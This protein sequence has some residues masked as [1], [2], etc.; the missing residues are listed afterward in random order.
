MDEGRPCMVTTCV[1]NSGSRTAA[2]A[3]PVI[4]FIKSHALISALVSAE[5]ADNVSR[6]QCN[7]LASR[8]NLKSVIN[9]P[10]KRTSQRINGI[11]WLD[12]DAKVY[13]IYG[14]FKVL[15]Y[16]LDLIAGRWENYLCYRL[17]HEYYYL[18]PRYQTNSNMIHVVRIFITT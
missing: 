2:A 18:H 1:R 5:A 7:T 10:I 4:L 9:Y 3:E 16:C 14:D 8:L 12:G 11:R 15:Q 6:L 17:Y 13:Q